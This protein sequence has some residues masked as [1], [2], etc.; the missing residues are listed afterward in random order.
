[1]KKAIR[2]EII[3]IFGNGG[4]GRVAAIAVESVEAGEANPAQKRIYA[5]LFLRAYH[6]RLVRSGYFRAARKILHCLSSG[7]IFVADGDGE[8]WESGM[9]ESLMQFRYQNTRGGFRVFP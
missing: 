3:C 9:A 4:F 5:R 2:D 1:M 8:M 6:R 7:R